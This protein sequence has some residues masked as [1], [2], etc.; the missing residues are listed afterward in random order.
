[1]RAAAAQ[2]GGIASPHRLRRAHLHADLHRPGLARPDTLRDDLASGEFLSN[3]L[4]L[5][6]PGHDTVTALKPVVD[7]STTTRR[8]GGRW[9]SR[10]QAMILAGDLLAALAATA[11]ALVIRFGADDELST[12]RSPIF[13]AVMPVGWIVAM[14]ANRAYEAR[15]IGAGQDEYRR[16]ARSFVHLGAG[17][18]ILSYLL[19]AQ[20][21]R[22]FVLVMLPLTFAFGMVGRYG[23]RKWLHRQRA[24]GRAMTS[25]L[26]V[27]DPKSIV[28]F[29]EMLRRDRY[30]GMRVVGACL[31]EY[32]MND[33]AGQDKLDAAGIPVLGDVDA[34]VDVVESSGARTVAVLASPQLGGKKLRWISWQLE[35][36]DANLVVSPGL[37]EVAG[38]RLH[39]QPVAGLPLVH[40]EEPEFSGAR[41]VMKGAFDRLAAFTAL[42]L[43]SPVVMAVALAV[44]TTSAGPIFFAQTRVGRDGK[45]FNILKFR[46]MS[47]DAEDRK[48]E[49]LHLNEN[50]GP[51]FKMQDDPRVTRIGRVI[52]KYSLDELPQLINV[53]KG[54]MSLVGP[55]PPLPGEVAEYADDVHRRLLVKPGLTGLGQISGRSKLKW[56]DAVRLDLRYVEN[57]SL[58]L[59]LM[60]LWKTVGAVLRG[61]GA[62]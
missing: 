33:G 37:I 2:R 32:A 43:L 1:M 45:R 24:A 56:D 3:D 4:A 47:V 13:A 38:N 21:A 28:E 22:G 17:V 26:V 7:T 29:D 49:L 48:D 10:Y 30:A 16:V 12:F 9:I 25:V 60:I 39:I 61:D 59:D 58:T 23:A 50:D 18:A 34:I 51:T 36:T 15:F 62:Y 52:R 20:I 5:G 8:R 55:R 11:V 6:A 14:T 42:V 31:P 27:G 19:N 41:R 40:V 57:W 54:E 35:G 44:K 53:V 46:S